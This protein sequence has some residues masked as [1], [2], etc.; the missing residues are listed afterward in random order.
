MFSPLCMPTNN[1]DTRIELETCLSAAEVESVGCYAGRGP[2]PWGLFDM[3]Y[4][5]RQVPALLIGYL[6]LNNPLGTGPLFLQIQVQIGYSYPAP[7]PKDV[8]FALVTNYMGINNSDNINRF[9]VKWASNHTSYYNFEILP[10]LA[11]L[12]NS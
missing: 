12:M 5:P 9:V 3:R 10:L 6:P 4:L 1:L 8:T 11:W 2:M 7:R